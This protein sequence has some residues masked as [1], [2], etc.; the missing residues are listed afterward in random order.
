MAN[1]DEEKTKRVSY[2]LITIVILGL[3]LLLSKTGL[4]CSSCM[5]SCNTPSPCHDEF[6]EENEYAHVQC[7]PGAKA[8]IVTS[9]PA[10]KAGVLCHC[11]NSDAGALKATPSAA[12]SH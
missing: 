3:F 6:Y 11:I 8:E 10:P 1:N 12:P 4:G 2:L 7:D 9:P 5:S